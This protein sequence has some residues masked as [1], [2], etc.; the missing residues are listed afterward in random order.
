MKHPI[1]VVTGAPGTVSAIFFVVLLLLY[2]DPR[3]DSGKENLFFSET[4]RTVSGPYD[5]PIY[6]VPKTLSPGRDLKELQA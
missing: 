4:S 1:P 2:Y 5:P 6:W 3:F